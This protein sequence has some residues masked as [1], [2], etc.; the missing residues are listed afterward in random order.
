[1]ADDGS[2][3][4]AECGQQCQYRCEKVIVHV[5]DARHATL[6]MSTSQGLGGAVLGARSA[7]GIS[8]FGQEAD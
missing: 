4:D 1:M 3:R 7:S 8:W 5:G 2:P 6:V